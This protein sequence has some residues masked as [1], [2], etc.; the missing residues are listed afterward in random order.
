MH[1]LKTFQPKSRVSH[2]EAVHPNQKRR[3][4]KGETRHCEVSHI[5]FPKNL[6]DPIES[7][8]TPRGLQES[9]HRDLV[10]R[11]KER[12]YQRLLRARKTGIPAWWYI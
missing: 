7:H 2:I 5:V 1:K 11:R 10:E 8:L 3:W 12:A 4:G 6:G 9:H